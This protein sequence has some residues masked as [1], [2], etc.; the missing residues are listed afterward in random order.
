MAII[1]VVFLILLCSFIKAP[2][3]NLQDDRYC[4]SGEGT[5]MKILDA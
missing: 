5:K 2:V 3:W 1:T 4:A